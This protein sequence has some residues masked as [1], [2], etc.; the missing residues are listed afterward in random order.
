MA[1]LKALEKY[2][3]LQRILSQM[4]QVPIRFDNV[5]LAVVSQRAVIHPK[6]IRNPVLIFL[7]G[8]VL[9]GFLALFLALIRSSLSK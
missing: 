6:P 2:D 4:I 7:V 8:V 9:S 1:A 3:E 5:Q